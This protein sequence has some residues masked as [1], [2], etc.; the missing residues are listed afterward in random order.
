MEKTNKDGTTSLFTIFNPAEWISL[1]LITKSS[2]RQSRAMGHFGSLLAVWS[3]NNRKY[4]MYGELLW[5]LLYVCEVKYKNFVAN[6]TLIFSDTQ[7]TK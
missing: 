3:P 1:N 4:V 2:W 6:N 7:E 5:T